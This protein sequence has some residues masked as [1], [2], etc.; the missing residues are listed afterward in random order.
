MYRDNHKEERKEYGKKYYDVHKEENKER[1]KQYRDSHKEERKEYGKKYRDS[2]KE[3]IAKQKKQ[4][5]INNKEQRQKYSKN[6]ND[7]HKESAQK[8]SRKRIIIRHG[9]TPEQYSEIFNKQQGCCNICG[10]HQSE[11]KKALHIDH[12]HKTKKIRGLLCFKC[13][14][15]LGYADDNIVRL[16]SAISYLKNNN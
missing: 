1:E 9:I 14:Y 2:H 13:N 8:R 11:M 12:N 3:K 7:T 5:Y 16:E 10:K 6:Y 15:L 4:Q